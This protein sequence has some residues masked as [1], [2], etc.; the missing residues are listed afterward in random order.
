MSNHDFS[1]ALQNLWGGL[2]VRREGWNGKGMH[3]ELVLNEGEMFKDG[4]MQEFL[5]MKTADGSYVPWLASQSDLL[6]SDW[7]AV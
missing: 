7:E 5:I 6:A 2:R 3:V 4:P 1:W